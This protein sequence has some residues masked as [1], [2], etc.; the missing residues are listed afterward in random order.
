MLRSNRD[1]LCVA[2]RCGPR[3][4]RDDL[5]AIPTCPSLAQFAIEQVYDT[6]ESSKLKT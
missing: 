4:V 5:S 3:L 1:Q 2:W 6:P